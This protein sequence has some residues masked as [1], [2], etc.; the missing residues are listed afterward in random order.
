MGLSPWVRQAVSAV[1]PS[2]WLAYLPFLQTAQIEM[3]A[4][5]PFGTPGAIS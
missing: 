5:Y 3:G 1:L 2:R 4:V